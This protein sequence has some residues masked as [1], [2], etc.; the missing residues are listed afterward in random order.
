VGSVYALRRFAFR[1]IYIIQIR[2]PNFCSKKS[3]SLNGKKGT[4]KAASVDHFQREI[5]DG[6]SFK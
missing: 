2:V 6:L 4:L 1:W 3:D 5:P